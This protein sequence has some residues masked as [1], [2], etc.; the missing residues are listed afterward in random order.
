M[1]GNTTRKFCVAA[2][3]SNRLKCHSF[4]FYLFSIF[5]YKIGEQ[6]RTSLA[7]GKGRH[8][9]ERERWQGMRVRCM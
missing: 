3:I 8:Q 6:D 5:F 9:W 4:L 7:L 2:F 1:H